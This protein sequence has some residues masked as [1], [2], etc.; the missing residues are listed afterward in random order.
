MLSDIQKYLAEQLQEVLTFTSLYRLPDEAVKAAER[1][2]EIWVKAIAVVRKHD[3]TFSYCVVVRKSDN[4]DR[5]VVVKVLG[6]SSPI[7]YGEDGNPVFYAVYP[8]KM[9]HPEFVRGFRGNSLEQRRE[10]LKTL[11]LPF[12]EARNGFE[13]LDLQGLN[14]MLVRAAIY[15]Q[16]QSEMRKIEKEKYNS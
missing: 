16:E 15:Q 5:A 4:I 2:S 8:Y 10:Y 11:R 14:K 6:T 1:A 13:E 7:V 12:D 3:G 9:L